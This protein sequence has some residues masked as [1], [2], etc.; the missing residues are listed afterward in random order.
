MTSPQITTPAE[1]DALPDQCVIRD[2]HGDVGVLIAGMVDYPE[3]APMTRARAYRYLPATLLFH[4]TR[5]LIAEAVEAER[6]AH[7]ETCSRREQWETFEAMV[8][9]PIFAACFQAEGT[10]RDALM[11]RLDELAAH[12]A[13]V[14][15]RALREA[16]DEPIRLS[17]AAV[18]T[19]RAECHKARCACGHPS[20][21]ALVAL[22]AGRLRDALRARAD[23][24]ERGETDG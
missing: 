24:I 21:D 23:R 19:E 1:L 6:E 10:L 8:A 5:D 15:A 13:E 17:R 22:I 3:T 11:A 7:D 2:R 4:P 12:D 16:A 18:I 20:E 14:A 9:H